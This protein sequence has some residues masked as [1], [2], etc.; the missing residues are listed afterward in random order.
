[1]TTG[2]AREGSVTDFFGVIEPFKDRLYLTK[3]SGLLGAIELTGSDPDGL[4]TYDHRVLSAIAQAIYSRLQRSI[5]ITQYY[6]HFGGVKVSLN[7]RE[8]IRSHTLSKRREAYLNAKALS[9]SRIVHYLEI[10]PDED[11]NQLKLVDL[12]RHI[13]AA[14]FSA[15]SREAVANRLRSD[16]AFLKA[17]QT[18]D[19]MATQLDEAIDEVVGKWGGVFQSRRLSQQETWAHMRFLASLNPAALTDALQEAIPSSDLDIY[20]SSGDVANL[21]VNNMDMLKLSGVTN[22]YARIAAVRRFV[23]KGGTMKPGLWAA[24]AKAPVRQTGN[25]LLMTRWKAMTEFERSWMFTKR[26]TELERSKLSVFELLKGGEDRSELERQAGTKPRLK[27]LI[28]DLGLAESIPDLW[29]TANAYVV[30]FGE[31]PEA[32]RRTGMQL[33]QAAGNAHVN[34]IWETVGIDKAFAALQPGQRHESQRDLYLTSAQFGAASLIHQASPGQMRVE[35]LLTN[36][37]PEEPQCYFQSRDGSLFGYSPFIGGRAVVVGTGPIRSGKSFLKNTCACQFLKYPRSLYRA[38]DIDPGSENLANLFTEGRGIFRVG[39]DGGLGF[40]P[41]ASCRGLKDQSFR[42]HFTGLA[43]EMLQANDALADRQ[44]TQPEQDAFDDSLE[45]TL[46]LTRAPTLSHFVAHLPESARRKF[47]RWVRARDQRSGN[48]DG[49]Y[50]KLFDADVDAIGALDARVGVFNLQALRDDPKG[51][52]PVMLETLYRITRGFEDPALQDVPKELDID[53]CHHL[54]AMPRAAEYITSKVRTWGK[55]FGSVHL[56]TQSPQELGGLEHWAA[57]RS[58]ATTFFF[59][60]DPQMDTGMYMRTFGLSAGQCESIRSLIPK[61]EA[62]IWQP[63]IG[64]SKVIVVDVEPEQRVF[65][66]SH[67]RE[68]ALRNRLIQEHGF[69]E[70]MRRAVIALHPPDGQDPSRSILQAVS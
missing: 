69:A 9:S 5:S 2:N 16:R 29:G 58:A 49:R 6:A 36:G 32:I 57:I 23:Q 1:M 31:D 20:L 45:Q 47:A 46:R 56:W 41:F 15:T 70:G 39:D 60:S 33:N 48:A 10:E 24:D 4:D 26:N 53:E 14:P 17:L 19:E 37:R 43:M 59:M 28:D 63:E 65:N 50:A 30:A 8:E 34:L 66:T 64:V 38:I 42:A 25:Y 61:R 27:K 21:Q 62:F 12:L 51:L 22:I 68:A 44:L 52:N 54:I 11:L 13:A 35:D 40:N 3:R 7:D 67:P 55:W 18:L